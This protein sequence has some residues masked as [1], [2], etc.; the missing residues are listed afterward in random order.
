[1]IG[2]IELIRRAVIKSVFL[3]KSLGFLLLS[4]GFPFL[5]SPLKLINIHNYVKVIKILLFGLANVG[6]NRFSVLFEKNISLV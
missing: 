1:M 2:G 4:K 5:F 6:K 3:I